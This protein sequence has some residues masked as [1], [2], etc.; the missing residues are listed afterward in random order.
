MASHPLVLVASI[1]LRLAGV[2]LGAILFA[3]NRD[4]RFAFFT[5]M[6]GLMALRQLLTLTGVT[7]WTTELPGLV[8]SVLA[9]ALGF[10]LLEHV[11]TEEAIRT[12][13]RSMNR[14]L[15]RSR[16][17]LE[18]I[19]AASPDYIFLFDEEARYA[20]I[21]SGESDITIRP[22]GEFIGSTV[23]EVLPDPSAA[24]VV[25]GA[26]EDTVET[27]ETRRIEYSL[28]L[29]AGPAWYEARTALVTGQGPDDED[30]VLLVARDVTER[31][32]RE[33]ENRRFR[34]AVEAAGNAIYITDRDGTIRYVND[35]FE[36]ITGYAESEALGRTPDLLS[37]DHHGEA[38]YRDLWETIRAGEVW[39]EEIVNE[40]RSGERYYA[41]QTIAPILDESGAVEAFV[42]VQTDITAR[43][44]RER[45]LRVLDRVLRHNLHNGMSVVLGYAETIEDETTG[46]VASAART[47]RERG[48][49]LL[50]TVDKEREIVELVSE[51]PKTE[52]VDLGTVVRDRAEAVR[53]D[54]PEATVT[55]EGP[56]HA[57]VRAIADVETAVAELLENAVVHDES[58]SPRVTATV[59]VASETV[60][61]AV[62]DTG[63]GIPE[64]ER[65]VLTGERDIRPLYHGSGLGL[66]LV[67]WIVSLSGGSLTFAEND[68]E[69]SV[70]TVTLA[71]AVADR[72][73]ADGESAD[74]R[75]G[76]PTGPRRQVD[77][78]PD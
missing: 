29:D 63:P 26:I 70:V 72:P 24:D 49:S 1:L 58:A 65:A 74:G 17:R 13:L 51:D 8:V 61:L 48:Q 59:D 53:S 38:Y 55:V 67:H 22:P 34:Q 54:H 10:Y 7:V 20:S 16:N 60:S 18:G 66:W 21:L 68:P 2:A 30:R 11:R 73:E 71:R 36:A 32:R 44:E 35:A 23:H 37:S 4:R 15:R 41:D 12:E 28:P 69:G 50:E 6:L 46:T 5:L 40:R 27:S 31:R 14:R 47:I 42:A 43:R 76:P 52:T 45:Q 57:F 56:A 77:D 62:A 19:L 33:Q 78:A 39:E 25:A 75:S 9:I 3:R 64:Q